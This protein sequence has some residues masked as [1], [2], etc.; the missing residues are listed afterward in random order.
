M[1]ADTEADVKTGTNTDAQPKPLPPVGGVLITVAALLQTALAGFGGAPLAAILS[2]LLVVLVLA[3]TASWVAAGSVERFRGPGAILILCS[4]AC[5]LVISALLVAYPFGALVVALM[6]PVL[7]TVATKRPWADLG[8][9][10]GRAPWRAFGWLVLSLLMCTGVWVLGT[11]LGL[12]GAGVI[13][14]FA[15]WVVFG[16]VQFRVLKGW[17]AILSRAFR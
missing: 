2:G 10:W 15:W 1:S 12:V 14:A 16:I 4:L 7:M 11:A 17:D 5:V 9:I 6:P 3:V 8:R 13:G